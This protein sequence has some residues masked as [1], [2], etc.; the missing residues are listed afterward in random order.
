MFK[1]AHF[2]LDKIDALTA[3]RYTPPVTVE[4]D[5]SNLCQLNCE[6]CMYRD[7]LRETGTSRLSATAYE[8]LLADIKGIV[9]SITFTGGGEPLTHPHFN[10]MAD[11]AYRDG[12]EM[13]LI[14]NGVNLDW[15]DHPE[16]FRFIRVSLDAGDRE[17]YRAVKGADRF[18]RVVDNLIRTAKRAQCLGISFVVTETNVD[19]RQKAA[20]LADEIGLA[21]VQFKPAIYPGGKYDRWEKVSNVRAIH[22]GRHAPSPTACRIAGLVGII[23][24]DATVY[25]CCQHRG[26]PDYALGSLTEETFTDIWRRRPAFIPN[27]R[28]CPPCRYSGYADEYRQAKEDMTVQ[29]RYFL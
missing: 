13:G 23:G 9:K 12:F 24:A 25:Y 16:R 5:P 27:L 20:E 14:T 18:D 4:I 11:M 1:K 22:T 2:Y 17:T 8:R 19:T 6:F 15:L 3:G 10:E 7:Y 26:D 29:H 21:Y 28:S